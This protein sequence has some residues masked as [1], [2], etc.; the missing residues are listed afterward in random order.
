M[1][2]LSPTPPHSPLSTSLSGSARETELRIRSIFQWKKKRP[3]VLL[4]ALVGAAIL[5]CGSLVSCQTESPGTSSGQ[6]SDGAASNPSVQSLPIKGEI[7]I[8]DQDERLFSEIDPA[9]NLSPQQRELLENLPIS[10]LPREA[11]D[12]EHLFR[13]AFWQDTLLP[14]VFDRETDTTL[15]LV[16]GADSALPQGYLIGMDSSQI[17]PA[18]IVLRHGDRAA[19]FPLVCDIHYGFHTI[20][21]EVSDFDEDGEKEAALGM[22]WSRGVGANLETL[23][24]FDL[25]TLTYTVPDFS[26][27]EELRAF[28]SPDEGTATLEAG[29]YAVTVP[30][31][32][33]CLTPEKVN[34]GDSVHF[35][36]PYGRLL[37]QVKFDFSGTLTGYLVQGTAS[38]EWDGTSWKLGE[39]VLAPSQDE[40]A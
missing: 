33:N 29:S 35:S 20:W 14:L 31:P 7:T 38:L 23:H 26:A 34:Y 21:M 15:Y 36:C 18:G 16:A 30:L 10:R 11:A 12:T 6:P 22:H 37:C 9:Q 32:E 19:Y 27:L 1:H 24:I 17:Q 3:P 39:M 4:M 28:W 40:F 25:E 5:L 8:P 2:P 13:Q